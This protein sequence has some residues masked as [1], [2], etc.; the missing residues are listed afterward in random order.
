MIPSSRP[1]ATFGVVVRVKYCTRVPTAFPIN[2]ASALNSLSSFIAIYSLSPW[3]PVSL[4][5]IYL[6][7]QHLLSLG[8]APQAICWNNIHAV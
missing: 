2:S 4:T 7:L 8:A 6:L 5:P 3:H 1:Q